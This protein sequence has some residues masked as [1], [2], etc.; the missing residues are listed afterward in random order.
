MSHW[1]LA[2]LRIAG[3]MRRR[4][5]H[6]A[7]G[8]YHDVPSLRCHFALRLKRPYRNRW[9]KMS[10]DQ[11]KQFIAAKKERGEDVGAFETDPRERLRQFLQEFGR[12][13]FGSSG[14][15][16]SLVLL[17]DTTDSNKRGGRY[18]ASFGNGTRMIW[19]VALSPDGAVSF[20]GDNV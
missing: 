6:A 1:L 20:D 5:S 3:L 18:L 2:L 4:E 17:E 19:T 7:S 8:H 12:R 15:L 16:D 9:K 13:R 10:A 14:T 11:R